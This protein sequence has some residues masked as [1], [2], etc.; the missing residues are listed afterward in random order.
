MKAW[1]QKNVNKEAHMEEKIDVLK[2]NPEQQQ[3]LVCMFFA[4]L[5]NTDSRYK[6]R[7]V[8]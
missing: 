8:C 5:P 7:V 3:A 2:L 6:K 1:K 4:M